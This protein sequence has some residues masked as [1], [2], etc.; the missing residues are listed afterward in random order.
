MKIAPLPWLCLLLTAFAAPGCRQDMYDQPK[1][2]P[3]AA[4]DFFPD[5]ASARPLIPGTIP[6][7]WL[8]D[9]PSHTGLS[10]DGKLLQTLPIPLTR[11][12]LERGHERFDIYCAE[13][14]DRA[15]T[16]RGMVVE[17]GFPAPPSLH[18]DRLREAPIGHFFD[19][20]THGYGA[21]YPYGSRVPPPDRWA[22]AAYIRALQLSQNARLEDLPDA[23]RRKLPPAS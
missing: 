4:S 17:R 11:Q 7:D 12:L 23:E 20:I 9:D 16:G 13:C 8:G 2:K 6:R 3:L 18:I 14:H 10:T 1:A 19:V 21:M 15:G 5:G 22:I